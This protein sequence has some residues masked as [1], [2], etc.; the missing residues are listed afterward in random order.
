MFFKLT[1][2][3]D[4]NMQALFTKTGLAHT[5]HTWYDSQGYDENT[6]TFAVLHAHMLVY[7]VHSGFA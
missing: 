4:V 6:L 2:M 5:A 3:S 7:F 1:G